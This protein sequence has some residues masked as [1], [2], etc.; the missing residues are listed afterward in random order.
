MSLTQFF[1]IFFDETYKSMLD[2]LQKIDPFCPNPGQREK[3]N[4]NF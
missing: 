2:V 3:I 1:W 4:F